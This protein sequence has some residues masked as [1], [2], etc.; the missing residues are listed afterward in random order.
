MICLNALIPHNDTLPHH[1]QVDGAIRAAHGG[2][3]NIAILKVMGL[4]PLFLQ[5]HL[6]E[7]SLTQYEPHDA[8]YRCR[9]HIQGY[10]AGGTGHD[11]IARVQVHDAG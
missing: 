11:K 7:Q 10:T 4:C 2:C 6:H 9:R 3:D 8:L 1:A 5:E